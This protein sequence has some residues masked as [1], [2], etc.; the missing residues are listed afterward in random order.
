M[1]MRIALVICAALALTVGVATA[2]GGN[3][4]NSA[5]AKTC[6]KGGWMLHTTA[7]GASFV[8]QSDCVSYAAGGGALVAKGKSQLDCESFGSAYSTDPATDLSGITNL[9]GGTFIWSCNGVALTGSQYST[10][11]ADCV[12]DTSNSYAFG[13][14]NQSANYS[15]FKF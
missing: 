15:C 9:P 7:S 10:L 3:G 12:A 8:N 14:A 13:N 11:A 2:S 5:N 1:T 4:G 6:Q